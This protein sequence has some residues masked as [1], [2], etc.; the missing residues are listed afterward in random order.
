MKQNLFYFIE[1]MLLNYFNE[2]CVQMFVRL[3]K[4]ALCVNETPYTFILDRCDQTERTHTRECVRR[5]STRG[6]FCNTRRSPTLYRA[7]PVI[8]RY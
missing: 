1:C 2:H 7:A 5:V 6:D 8:V 3:F 4:F